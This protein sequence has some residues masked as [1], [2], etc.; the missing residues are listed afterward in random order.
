MQSGLL[1]QREKRC[2]EISGDATD[3][4]ST[5]RLRQVMTGYDKRGLRLEITNVAADRLQAVIVGEQE[6]GWPTAINY[7]APRVYAR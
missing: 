3:V 5:W 1:L 7:D 4:M 6:I 2:V